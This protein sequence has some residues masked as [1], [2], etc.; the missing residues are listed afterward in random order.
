VREDAGGGTRPPSSTH[1]HTLLDKQEADIRKAS[2]GNRR[3]L[4]WCMRVFKQEH[5][6]SLNT[7]MHQRCI[8]CSTDRPVREH[9]QTHT[10]TIKHTHTHRTRVLYFLSPPPTRSRRGSQS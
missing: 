4:L 7:L 1:S 6:Y 3:K 8:Q 10:K 9:T 2:I 5:Q